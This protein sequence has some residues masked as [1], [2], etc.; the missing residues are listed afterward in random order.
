M[1]VRDR[2]AEVVFAHRGVEVTVSHPSLG[3]YD[4]V[5]CECGKQFDAVGSGWQEH[6]ADLLM[7]VLR[8]AVAP[9]LPR[10]AREFV[11]LESP[12]RGETPAECV[13]NVQYARAALLDSLSR[14]EAPFASHLLYPQVLDDGDPVQRRLGIDAGLEVGRF[15][16]RTVAYVDRGVSEGMRIG[17]GLSG[18]PV[19]FRRLGGAWESNEGTKV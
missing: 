7:Q 3:D 1:G 17:F 12:F 15:A 11:V 2:V 13:L 5:D 10:L 8:L 4:R 9:S 14:G 6:V 18:R 19:E 16:S